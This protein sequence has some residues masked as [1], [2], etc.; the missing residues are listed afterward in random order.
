MERKLIAKCRV[1]I[2]KNNLFYKHNFLPKLF[3]L[4]VTPP[5]RTEFNFHF[6]LSQLQ[7][8]CKSSVLRIL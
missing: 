1:C 3:N 4:H 8:Q 6:L 7:K 5:A 2:V